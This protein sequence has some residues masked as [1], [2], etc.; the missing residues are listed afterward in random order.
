MRICIVSVEYPPFR[1]GGIGTYAYNMSRFLA[2]AG[3]EVH[4]IANA[5]VDQA[6]T[7]PPPGTAGKLVDSPGRRYH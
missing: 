3:H 7:T 1:G 2:D 4:V 5:W 6:T